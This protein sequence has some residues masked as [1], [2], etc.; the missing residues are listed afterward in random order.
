[1]I[2]IKI[3]YSKIKIPENQLDEL[4][5]ENEEDSNPSE[6]N[7]ASHYRPNTAGATLFFL[8]KIPLLF[9]LLMLCAYVF[10]PI[11]IIFSNTII[12]FSL[13]CSTIRVI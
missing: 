7:H 11:C 1:M 5:S 3:T 10:S 12:V 8:L 13:L 2:K 6:E 9:V 4:P